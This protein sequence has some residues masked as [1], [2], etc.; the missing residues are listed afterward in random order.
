[1]SDSITYVLS[2][3][4]FVGG[5]GLA[6]LGVYC[7]DCISKPTERRRQVNLVV[8]REASETVRLKTLQ[9]LFPE[10]VCGIVLESRVALTKK[11]VQRCR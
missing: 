2:G 5:L 11:N 3:V 7:M 1:M 4:T 10:K 6:W 8:A 9:T